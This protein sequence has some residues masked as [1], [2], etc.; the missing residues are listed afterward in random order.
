MFDTPKRHLTEDFFPAQLILVLGL[1]LWQRRVA[2]RTRVN[3]DAQVA[4]RPR[5]EIVSDFSAKITSSSVSDF[6][7]L[8]FGLS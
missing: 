7:R 2:V 8:Q 5:R 4:W 1:I 3:R 6:F